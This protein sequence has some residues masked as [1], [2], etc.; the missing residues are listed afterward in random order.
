MRCLASSFSM[1]NFYI[2]CSCRMPERTNEKASSSCRYQEDSSSL[3]F[4]KL[5]P[6]IELVISALKSSSRSGRL[7][8][9]SNF[10]CVI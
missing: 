6:E 8:F 5:S 7:I 3:N 9:A 10:Q 1:P 4:L 2:I